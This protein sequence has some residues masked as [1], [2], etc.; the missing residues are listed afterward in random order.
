VLASED[1]RVLVALRGLHL[2]EEVSS[3]RLRTAGDRELD[4]SHDQPA[5]GF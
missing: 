2:T 3:L 5:R 4:E 1:H